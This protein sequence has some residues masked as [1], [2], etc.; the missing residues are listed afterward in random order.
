MP[1]CRLQAHWVTEPADGMR[2]VV[3]TEADPKPAALCGRMSFKNFNPNTES[4][5]EQQQQQQPTVEAGQASGDGAAG[6]SVT[7]Q[8]MADQLGRDSHAN[9]HETHGHGG[10]L[11]LRMQK[12]RRRG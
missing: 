10:F 4:L 5:Q 2:C 6:V 8:D 3:I 1:C 11:S 7:D 12:R 9:E